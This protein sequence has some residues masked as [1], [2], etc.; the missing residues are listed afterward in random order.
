M[1]KERQRRCVCVRV[2][3]CVN[4]G[5]RQC[6]RVCCCMGCAGGLMG[7]SEVCEGKGVCPAPPRPAQRW[8]GSPDI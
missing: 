8:P 1:K 4:G 7:L 3:Y 5:I 2:R 6:R